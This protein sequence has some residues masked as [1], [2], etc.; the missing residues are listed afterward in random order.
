MLVLASGAC[1]PGHEREDKA[2][3]QTEH[4]PRCGSPAATEIIIIIII[5]IIIIIMPCMQGSEFLPQ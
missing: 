4:R 3:F 5:V 2:S 1:V